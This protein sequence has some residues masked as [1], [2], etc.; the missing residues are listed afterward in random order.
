MKDA[1]E[2]MKMN[3][4]AEGLAILDDLLRGGSPDPRV[5]LYRG[6][7][8][9]RFSRRAEDL[10]AF[11]AAAAASAEGSNVR[12]AARKYLDELA[13]GSPVAP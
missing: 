2:L 5:Q 1:T 3:K 10:Q 9:K 13:P 4:V 6:I 11:K 8:L 12:A 7:A